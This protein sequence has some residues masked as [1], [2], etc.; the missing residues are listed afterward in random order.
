MASVNRQIT[1]AA[2]P[3]G[4]PKLSDFSLTYV[5]CHPPADGEVLLRAVYLSL[6][7][8]QRLRMN[9]A[10]A[11]GRSVAIGGVM[12][13]TA[14]AVVVESRDARFR[15]GDAVEGML[16]WQELAVTPGR[17]LRRLDLRG[18]P[19]ST[20][21]G[22]LGLP[23]LTAYFGLLHVARPKPGETVVVSDAAGGV[24]MLAGQIARLN[25]CR[26]VGVAG[27]LVEISWLRDELGFDAAL[28]FRTAGGLEGDL[29]AF[30]PRG[31]D[32]YFDNAGG[33]VSDA[34]VRRINRGG[35]IAL[36]GQSSQYDLDRPQAGPRWMG[37]LIAQRARAEGFQVADFA[38]RF[39][40][41]RRR[42]LAWLLGGELRYR[43][44]VT[45]G[46]ESAPS[47]FLGMLQGKSLGKQLVQISEAAGEVA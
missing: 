27:S 28:G 41:A 10:V 7:P 19:I 44:Q 36:C 40:A 15:V 2:R 46:L 11:G 13:G 9:E 33:E 4:P 29:D 45:R 23:G 26:V 22:V 39:A 31:V 35:R 34:V 17:Q 30:C 25:G 47:A 18:L 20:A 5:A 14:A 42:L 12:A 38:R 24:G 6:D 3:V 43:E 8:H 1:L 37:E 32:V 21:L 16:G